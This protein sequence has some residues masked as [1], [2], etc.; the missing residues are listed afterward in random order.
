[1]HTKR[2]GLRGGWGHS[3]L[4]VA[5]QSD[6][7][8]RPFNGFLLLHWGH[9]QHHWD[10]CFCS[11]IRLLYSRLKELSAPL[12]PLLLLSRSG[13]TMSSVPVGKHREEIQDR[14]LRERRT[15]WCIGTAWDLLCS[16]FSAIL[17]VWRPNHPEIMHQPIVW[18]ILQGSHSTCW[19]LLMLCLVRQH[20]NPSLC[21]PPTL[22]GAAAVTRQ[23]ISK[24]SAALPPHSSAKQLKPHERGR[25][26]GAHS[27]TD[28]SDVSLRGQWW[29]KLSSNQYLRK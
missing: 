17:K 4:C 11:A 8:E 13:Y 10:L 6:C 2:G 26:N 18:S 29:Q 15:F 5:E 3:T 27:S 25:L 19:W 20:T 21:P 7:C 9:C 1:M 23:T 14:A 28:S 12:R 16:A 24:E 22:L